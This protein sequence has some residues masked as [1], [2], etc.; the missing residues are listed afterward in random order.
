[1]DT[2]DTYDKILAILR[3][4]APEALDAAIAAC[5][6]KPY[7]ATQ[8]LADYQAGISRVLDARVDA[9]RMFASGE[10]A[11]ADRS[12]MPTHVPVERD[13][14]PPKLNAQRLIALNGSDLVKAG[15]LC[16]PER[17]E[18]PDPAVIGNELLALVH[19][20]D[21]SAWCR[22]WFNGDK[23]Q[24]EYFNDIDSM[25]CWMLPPVLDA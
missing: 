8:A 2:P 17:G 22:A 20:E 24:D 3:L 18:W 15:V 10:I 16:V 9:E 23:W 19:V 1:M 6:L 12:A 7:T 25:E 13:T 11:P 14:V 4:E 5:E 21:S